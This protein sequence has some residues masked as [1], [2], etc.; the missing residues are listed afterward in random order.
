MRSQ[1]HGINQQQDDGDEDANGLDAP[2]ILNDQGG[3]GRNG[4][5]GQHQYH[6]SGIFSGI[7]SIEVLFAPAPTAEASEEP[8]TSSILL[9]IEP[10][11]EALTT[12]ISPCCSAKMPIIISG[13]LPKVALSRPPVMLPTCAARSSVAKPINAARGI[14]LMAAQIKMA[15]SCRCPPARSIMGAKMAVI[16][17][18]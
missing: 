17:K 14:R 1:V 12:E 7:T 13:A 10:M 5:R 3:G 8:R 16:S 4:E 2:T 15:S 6:H 9:M 18:K 11:I